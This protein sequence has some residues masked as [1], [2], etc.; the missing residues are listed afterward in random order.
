M[1]TTPI[2]PDGAQVHDA[3]DSPESQWLG[4]PLPEM[5]TQAK[6]ANLVALVKTAKS[7]PPFVV[8]HGGADCLVPHG[9][10][11]ALTAALKAR[12]SKVS[13]SVID[14]AGHDIDEG[15]SPYAPGLAQVQKLLAG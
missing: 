4:G 8:A 11:Q 15:E 12:G 2:T 5:T 7:L 14:G 13:L 1:T 3:A 9:Q 6:K 10:S